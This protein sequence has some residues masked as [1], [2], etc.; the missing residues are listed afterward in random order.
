MKVARSSEL[1]PI[2]D[3]DGLG[4]DP[5]DQAISR[6]GLKHAVDMH[7]RQAS[8]I[9]QLVLCHWKL[10][11]Q[12][13]KTDRIQLEPELAK[14]VRDTRGCIA[15]SHIRNPFAMDGPLGPCRR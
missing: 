8:G 3:N 9:C 7:R 15:P 4:G 5:F 13:I 12:L 11:V 10:V 14:Q 1:L 6:E 2:A